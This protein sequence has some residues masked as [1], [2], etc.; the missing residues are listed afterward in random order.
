MKSKLL[1]SWATAAALLGAAG[2]AQASRVNWSV[3]I[4]GGFPVVAAAPVYAPVYVQPAPV[5]APPPVYYGP[6]A[7]IYRPAPVVYGPPVYGRPM[8]VYGGRG[9]RNERHDHGHDHGRHGGH[10]RGGDG[11]G[12]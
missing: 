8:P 7:V 6:P 3:S 5:Y 12:R 1:L 4:G 10:G 2:A 9:W 11:W